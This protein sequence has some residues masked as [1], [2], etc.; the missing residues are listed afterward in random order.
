LATTDRFD[1]LVGHAGLVDL[2]GQWSTSDVIYHRERMNDG[3]PWGDSEV[4][5]QQSPSTY[6]DEFSTP[7]MLTIGESDYRVPLNQ[8]L[9]AWSYLQR[10]QVPSRLL[11]FHDA[12]HWIMKGPEAKHFWAE[13]HEWLAEYLKE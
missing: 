3:P 10:M 2:E 9:A 11:V 5:E 4:W 12:N 13:V 7:T 1:A 6:A 8:T